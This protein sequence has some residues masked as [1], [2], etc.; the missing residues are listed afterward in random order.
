[1]THS[2]QL[3]LVKYSLDKG[4]SLSSFACLPKFKQWS[5][6]FD[7]LSSRGE[8]WE[9]LQK[10]QKI[11]SFE[12]LKIVITFPVWCHNH[13]LLSVLHR[14]NGLK[15][16]PWLLYTF[17][18]TNYPVWS[19]RWN[20]SKTFHCPP[21]WA[22]SHLLVKCQLSRLFHICSPVI[23]IKPDILRKCMAAKN[24]FFKTLELYD[25]QERLHKNTIMNYFI[26]S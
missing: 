16:P 9:T 21:K 15:S 18:F 11:S 3:S 19:W 2:I 20:H 10:K 7:T 12:R 4:K 24:Q 13:K 26:L 1:M 22:L 17:L 14:P 6:G 8:K 25:N 23:V 5:Q